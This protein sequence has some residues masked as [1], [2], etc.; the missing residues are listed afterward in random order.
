MSTL[1]KIRGNTLEQG[2]PNPVQII[3]ANLEALNEDVDLYLVFRV[4]GAV[5]VT[6]GS[7]CS[8]SYTVLTGIVSLENGSA[9]LTGDGTAFTTELLVGDKI[10][11][12]G[13]IFEILS[14][15]SDTSAVVLTVNDGDAIDGESASRL[16]IILADRTGDYTKTTIGLSSTVT[17]V[18]PGAFARLKTW[19]ILTGLSG[20]T[21][22]QPYMVSDTAGSIQLWSAANPSGTFQIV[23]FALSTTEF[24][25]CIQPPTPLIYVVDNIIRNLA[26]VSQAGTPPD[27]TALIN[28]ALG[29]L[30]TITITGANS[31][32]TVTTSNIVAGKTMYVRLVNSTSPGSALTL[33]LPSWT[34][35]GGS[36][37]ATLASAKT[38]L[39][40]LTSFGTTDESTIAE[41]SV[42]S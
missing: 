20:L 31:T 32:L 22:G 2:S 14:I 26:T 33:T 23:G 6:Y 30:K 7:A 24:F 5:N 40:K 13:R 15:S 41:Y 38:A 19:G 3:D 35:V 10:L 1:T 36:A 37:P 21:A 16:E 17:E 18:A 11:V 28:F 25:I 42:E 4:G 39:L 34:W 12:D 9:A 27:A 29:E 8:L